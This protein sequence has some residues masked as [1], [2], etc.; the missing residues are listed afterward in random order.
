MAA[1]VMI[2]GLDCAE[3]SLVLERWRG[4]LPT[5]SGLM[6]RGRYGRLRSVVPPIT[7]PAWSCMMASR[8]PGD[9]GIYGF[10]NRADHSYDN[11]VVA[12][13]SAVHA[14][15]LWDVATRY[16]KPSIVVGVPGTYP[17]RPLNGV[18]VSCFLTPS[19]ESG[20]TYPPLL[21][22]EVEQVVG[23][24][25][26]DCT[27]FRTEDKED[28]L[29]QVYEMTD[30]RFQLA[31]HLLETKPWEL[32]ALVEIGLDRM[33]H[34]FWKDLDELHH[35]HEPDGPYA[36]AILDYLRHLDGLIARLLEHADEETVVLVVSDH[37]AKRMEGGIRINEWLRGQGLLQT[38]REPEGVSALR[39]VG[40]D[41]SRT[42]AW[43]EGGYYGRVFLNVRGREPEGTV[44]PE[45]FE[46]VRDELAELL[47]AIPG[48]D[49]EPLATRVYRPEE[50][51]DEVNGIAPDL[52]VYFDDLAWRAVGTV[53]G[54]EGVHTF[55]NDTG[56][57]DAN[58]AQ[59]GL[60]IMAGPGVE[61]GQAETMS[62]LDV[63]PTVLELLGLEPLPAMRG[64]SLLRS[65]E[66]SRPR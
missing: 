59:D 20:F 6:E 21:A 3:P 8:T 42:T 53:G 9:L 43:G 35:R 48:P 45:D 38:A 63:A 16:G 41:W 23:E 37:G 28:L 25:L 4:E 33:H 58:H 62:L 64:S 60:L 49:G 10:R 17:P 39:D 5:L 2:I 57:D 46:R 1:K 14:P 56:P 47:A 26:F 11:L 40:V 27:N 13:G 15:R 19:R 61:P 34:G 55:E 51:Y 32:F 54:D 12:D 36:G 50:V 52:L 65:E 29:R 7:V 31:E 44:E 24:Y 66:L 30:R 22:R 18:M